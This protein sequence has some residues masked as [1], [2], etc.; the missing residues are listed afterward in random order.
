MK[1][2]IYSVITLLIYSTSCGLFASAN[3][4]NCSM[5]FGFQH[6]VRYVEFENI[7]DYDDGIQDLNR[8]F[9]FRTQ[10]WTSWKINRNF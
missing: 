2:Y 1:V 10:F 3:A 7:T 4:A 9:R 6:R 5:S 8:F